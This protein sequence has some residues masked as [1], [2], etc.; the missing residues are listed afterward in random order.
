MAEVRDK[1]NKK[2]YKNTG[3]ITSA[4]F[5]E[6]TK[7]DTGATGATGSAGATGP[8]DVETATLEFGATALTA[9]GAVTTGST[10]IGAYVYNT[11]G[12]PAPS[13][14]KLSVTNDVLT[15]TLTSAPGT[16]DGLGFVVTLK[17]V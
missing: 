16:G 2:L 12:D 13:H 7:G 3:T 9:T 15:G 1:T 6:F 5:T 4:E 8:V 11:T 10:P 17:K 14:L